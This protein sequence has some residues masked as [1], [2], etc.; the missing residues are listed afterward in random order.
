MPY[1]SLKLILYLALGLAFFGSLL[2]AAHFF[3]RPYH[4]QWDVMSKLAEPRFN[5]RAY[6]VACGGLAVS[7]VLL[8]AFPSLL[9][10]RLALGSPAAARWGGGVLYIAAIFLTLSG[11]VPGHVAGLGHWHEVLAHIYGAAISLAMLGYFFAAL[12]LPR[13]FACQRRAG[14]FLVVIP[15]SGF[16]A[17][18]LSLGLGDRLVSPTAYHA[19]KLNVWNSLALWE[20]VAAVGTYVYLGLLLTLPATS[21][22]ATK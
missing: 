14:I 16:L 15:L 17:S 7:G 1:E 6:L 20:W 2:Q 11:V 4:W 18:R 5:P 8:A 9:R 21:A 22:K 12:G 13:R 3:P 19:L 10:R